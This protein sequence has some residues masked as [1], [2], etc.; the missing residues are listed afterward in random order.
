MT[1]ERSFNKVQ[2]N[3][4]MQEIWWSGL[5]HPSTSQGNKPVKDE[6]HEMT[7]RHARQACFHAVNR[8]RRCVNYANTAFIRLYRRRFAVVQLYRN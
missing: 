6:N 5:L 8:F 7:S 2:A 1:G 4:N 3:E